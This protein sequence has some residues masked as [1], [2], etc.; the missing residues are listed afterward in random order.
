MADPCDWPRGR[1]AGRD[2]AGCGWLRHHAC[3]ARISAF[4]R[5]TLWERACSRWHHHVQPDTPHRLL[6]EQAR[7]HRYCVCHKSSNF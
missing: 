6:R 4:S 2:T 7:S 5:L 1:R 3:S